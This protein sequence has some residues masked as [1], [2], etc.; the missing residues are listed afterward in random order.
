MIEP[1]AKSFI[2]KNRFNCYYYVNDT[3]FIL[4]I[5]FI[6]FV[7]NIVLGSLR[8]FSSILNLW[9]II[10]EDLFRI[11]TYFYDSM[12]VLFGWFKLRHEELKLGIPLFSGKLLK[13]SHNFIKFYSVQDWKNFNLEKFLDDDGPG[14]F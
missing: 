3:G 5:K 12:A 4:W 6:N 2:L 14:S 8:T 11:V 7:Y 9:I 1:E 13:N 10:L